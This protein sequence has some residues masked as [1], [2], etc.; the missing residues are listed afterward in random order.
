MELPSVSLEIAELHRNTHTVTRLRRNQLLLDSFPDEQQ[1][2]RRDHGP[3]SHL[4][5][6]NPQ[7]MGFQ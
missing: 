2:C 6:E 3:P 4:R 5:P 1:R 7:N